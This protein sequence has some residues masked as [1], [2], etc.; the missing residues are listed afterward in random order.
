MK[1]ME[2]HEAT[3]IVEKHNGNMLVQLREK[4]TGSIFAM[5]HEYFTLMRRWKQPEVYVSL[6]M[7]QKAMCDVLDD[8]E[9]WE[10]P[11]APWINVHLICNHNYVLLDRLSRPWSMN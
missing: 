4:K 3:V 8:Y 1:T 11:L 2:F 10:Y 6:D 7:Q 5:K 9:I